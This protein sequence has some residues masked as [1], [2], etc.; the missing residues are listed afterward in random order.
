MSEALTVRQVQTMLAAACSEAGSQKAW[1][2][3]HGI[4]NS[5][6][7]NV[8]RGWRG[9]GDDILGALGLQRVVIRAAASEG[10]GR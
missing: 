1:A 5:Y 10:R 8:L 9:P 3:R 7:N 4:S 2:K 6:V